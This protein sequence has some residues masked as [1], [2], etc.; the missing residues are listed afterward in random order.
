ML[1]SEN[2]QQAITCI[3]YL[4]NVFPYSGLSAIPCLSFFI[5]LP[6]EN[7]T[8]HTYISVLGE[9]KV[10]NVHCNVWLLIDNS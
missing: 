7:T 1:C 2:C 9:I 4:L 6:Q 3:D 5:C 10:P 8:A